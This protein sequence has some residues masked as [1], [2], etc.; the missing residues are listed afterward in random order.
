MEPLYNRHHWEPTPC[1]KV[2][3]TQGLPVGV[4]CIIGLFKH[5]VAAF[6]MVFRAFLCSMLVGKAKQRLVL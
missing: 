5:N 4:V 3:L 2:S 6:S 1:S